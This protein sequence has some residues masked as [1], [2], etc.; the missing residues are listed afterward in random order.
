[1]TGWAEL[2]TVEEGAGAVGVGGVNGMGLPELLLFT[3]ST[4]F[5]TMRKPNGD[6]EFPL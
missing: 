4:Y 5:G 2:G 1:V 3:L 6:L